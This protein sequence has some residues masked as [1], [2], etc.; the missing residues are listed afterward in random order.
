MKIKNILAASVLLFGTTS[1]FAEKY[2]YEIT[3]LIGYNIAEGNINVDDYLVFGAEFQF[4]NLLLKVFKPELSVFYAKADYDTPA[5]DGKDSDI[6]RF[7]F[8]GVYEYHEVMD[9]VVIP[10]AKMGIGYEKFSDTYNSC[11]YNSFYIDAGGGAKL[12]LTKQWALKA[13]ALYMVKDNSTRWDSNFELLLGITYAFG[14][15]EEQRYV[16]HSTQE[17]KT[18][19]T[20]DYLDEGVSGMEVFADDD[21]DG[22]L[23]SK[24]A[25]SNTPAGAKVDAKGCEIDSDGDGLV[26]SKDKCPH[27]D[28]NTQIDPQ[29]GCEFDDDN[30]TVP[31]S[32]DTC[33]NTAP[34]AKVDLQ[35]CEFDSDGD[36]VVDS[37]DQCPNTPTGVK[38]DTK[39]CFHEMNL[40]IN[41]KQGLS[42]VDEASMEN[43][44]RFAEFLKSTPIYKVRIVGYTDSIGSA[45]ANR[46]LSQRRAEKVKELLIAAGVDSAILSSVGRGEESPVASNATKEGRAKNRRIEAE[47]EK[48]K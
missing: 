28:P 10:F 20:Q 39:G 9:G 15:G 5:L 25:C 19:Q 45:A 8:N 18:Q 27:S 16:E 7:A 37:Q 35:G 6:Y 32:K 29:T 34:G 31:N 21:K 12:L 1:A 48:I 2:D 36:G 40:S 42:D 24:D 17:E 44:K 38:V 14:G 22:V 23:N 47:L 3:P 41:F 13:E 46:K 26:D 4:N 11:N 30:D 33:P 43:I